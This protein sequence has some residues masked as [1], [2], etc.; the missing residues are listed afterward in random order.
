MMARKIPIVATL[1]VLAAVAVMIRLGFWQVQRMHEKDAL[2]ARYTAAQASA[3]EASWDG[4][5]ATGQQLLFRRSRLTCVDSR[6]LAPMAGH[7][8]RRETGWSQVLLCK[9]PSGYE[10]ELV[11]GWTQAPNSIAVQPA[12]AVVGWIAP[13][14]GDE[15]RFVADP[16]L[17]QDAGLQPNAR[18]D[19]TAIPNNHWSYAVQW[20]LFA[21]VALVIYGLA[22]RKRLLAA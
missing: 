3:Q 18:P 7:N 10:V 6:P 17:G 1:V 12:Q 2:L 8:A 16:A 20:F 22:L 9:T 21:G 13:G 19:P 14:R 15:V 4:N 5:Q 11:A